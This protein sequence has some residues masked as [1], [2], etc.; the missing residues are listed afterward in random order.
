THR[1][2]TSVVSVLLGTG[3][4]TFSQAPGSPMNV[5][6]DPSD[7]TIGDFNGDGRFDLAVTVAGSNSVAI[8][9][10]NGNGTFAQ[11]PGSPIAGISNPNGVVTGRFND[12]TFEDLAVA[13]SGS[14]SVVLLVGNGA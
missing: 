12:D 1:S 3:N 10:G 14:N 6:T 8:L 2:A 5:G 7:L 11:A 13:S 9:L 4:F